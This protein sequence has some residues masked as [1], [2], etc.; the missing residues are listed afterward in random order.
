MRS[1]V[2]YAILAMCSAV[3][4]PL[5]FANCGKA[6]EAAT[7]LALRRS[8]QSIQ[9]LAKE[10]QGKKGEEVANITTKAS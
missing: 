5:C 9:R 7:S 1:F 10:L 2:R 8:P 4:I 3:A 6:A